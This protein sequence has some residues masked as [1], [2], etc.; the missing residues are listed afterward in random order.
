RPGLK[1][2]A[3]AIGNFADDLATVRIASIVTGF[4]QDARK[5]A[6][7]IGSAKHLL[8]TI[9]RERGAVTRWLPPL[10][11]ILE[12]LC[13][14]LEPLVSARLYGAEGQRAQIALARFYLKLRRFPEA[15]IVMRES[16]V[17]RYA[18]D[19]TAVEVN[20]PAF[21]KRARA[22]TERAFTG[23]D[24]SART[25][26]DIR[27][28]I[29]HGGF[30]P[31]PVKAP[32]LRR[33]LVAAVGCIDDAPSVAATFTATAPVRWFVSRHQGAVDWAKSHGVAVDRWATHL[34]V[35]QVR[36]GDVVMGS[37]PVD[38]AAAVCE[39]GA[40]YHH[41]HVGLPP[42]A[43]GQELTAEHLAALG[44]ELRPFEIR[45]VSLGGG[46]G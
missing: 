21:S 27:N 18:A 36:E 26:A 9:E 37:L 25:I 40:H 20:D 2:V 24:P 5:K 15:A 12:D 43:R 44:A 22:A 10:A 3:T 14:D 13:R 45:A 39:R 1:S 34:D 38:L 33:N 42:E 8:N 30:G 29:E 11:L 31:Q 17:N 19:A 41:L 4:E 35:A 23:S 46:D 32:K 7:A 6:R 28:D 16:H